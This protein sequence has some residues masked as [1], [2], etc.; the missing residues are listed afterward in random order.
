[1]L[2]VQEIIVI[3]Y[4]N[5]GTDK[6]HVMHQVFWVKVK[7]TTKRRNSKMRYYKYNIND[8]KYK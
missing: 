1:M 8:V 5:W 2:S 4:L 3:T 7:I 6:E